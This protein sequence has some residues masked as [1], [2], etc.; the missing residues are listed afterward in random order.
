[1][2]IQKLTLNQTI[3]NLIELPDNAKILDLGCRDA[4]YLM[5][6]IE[7]QPEKVAMAIGVDVTSRGFGAIPYTS[8][9]ELKVMDCSQGLDFPDNK[10][11]LVFT[12]D[13]LE[14]IADKGALIKEIHRVLKPKG[15]VICVH[16]DFDSIIYNGENKELITKAVHA[17][18]ETQQGWMDTSDGWMG[19]RLYGLFSNSG[20]FEGD[21]SVYNL[22]ET[23]YV[24]GSMGYEFSRLVSFLAKENTGAL[25]KE[26]YAELIGELVKANRNGTYL[27]NRPYYIYRGCKIDC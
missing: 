8:P 5:S 10:F 6:F 7:A 24:E 9:V 20:L 18:A 13:M 1:M 25:S 3:D 2:K 19:R 4:G 11:D 15:T 14:C 17:Y 21:I 22:V 27:F 23:E 26:E 16:T 12:K